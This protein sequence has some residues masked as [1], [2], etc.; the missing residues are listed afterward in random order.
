MPSEEIVQRKLRDKAARKAHIVNVARRIAELDGWSSVTVR[1]LAEEI[2]FSQP[3]LYAH[4]GSREGIVSA[5]A[6]EGFQELGLTLEKA[7]E[8]LDPHDAM[9]ALAE[10]YLQ[11]AAASPALYE[12]MFSLDVHLPF[13]EADS[14]PELQFAFLQLR[15]LFE[16]MGPHADVHAE[17][18]WSSLHGLAQLTGTKRLPPSRQ[19]ERVRTLVRMFSDQSLFAIS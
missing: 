10:A 1:R 9:Q 3:V 17:V 5:V 7:R 6:V 12:A 15:R 19:K 16:T 11:F 18:F 14:P 4:F 2:A 13:G 8:Q